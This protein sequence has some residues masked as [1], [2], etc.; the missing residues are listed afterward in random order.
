MMAVSRWQSEAGYLLPIRRDSLCLV[1]GLH[2]EGQQHHPAVLCS[3]MQGSD[4]VAA[5]VVVRSG[6]PSA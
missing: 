2:E 6:M 4:P 5:G 1:A 3:N